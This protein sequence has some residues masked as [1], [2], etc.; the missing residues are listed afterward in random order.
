MKRSNVHCT[1]YIEFE[2]YIEY[3]VGTQGGQRTG[4]REISGVE[5]TGC[6]HVGATKAPRSATVVIHICRDRVFHWLWITLYSTLTM[7]ASENVCVING[8]DKRRGKRD[9]HCVGDGRCKTNFCRILSPITQSLSSSSLNNTR[10]STQPMKVMM[11]NTFESLTRD[12]PK[13]PELGN[14]EGT[15]LCLQLP[16]AGPKFVYISI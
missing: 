16:Q 2:V 8:G 9:G 4:R 1:M 10:P 5:L 14:K 12:G 7:R 3:K 11:C 15:K 13:Q 6:C